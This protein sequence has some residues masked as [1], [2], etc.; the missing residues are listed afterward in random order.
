MKNGN[1]KEFIEMIYNGEDIY[2]VFGGITYFAQGYSLND[3]WHYEIVQE[4]PTSEFILWKFD[5]K[6]T[7]VINSF[8]KAK[9]FNGKTFWEVEKDIEW[10]DA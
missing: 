7:D 6:I 3:V 5:G 8:E 10:V 4:S 9:I 1:P 2:F